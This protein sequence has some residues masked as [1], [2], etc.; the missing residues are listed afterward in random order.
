LCQMSYG[1]GEPSTGTGAKKKPSGKLEGKKKDSRNRN[2][3]NEGKGRKPWVGTE[4]KNEEKKRMKAQ[5]REKGKVSQNVSA[6]RRKKK[7]TIQK[8]KKNSSPKPIGEVK[9]TIER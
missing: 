1:A 9:V 3:Q 6:K 4:Q 5:V 8:K 2:V 7:E